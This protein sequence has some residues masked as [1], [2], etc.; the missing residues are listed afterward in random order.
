MISTENQLEKPEELRKKLKIL[1]G[2]DVDGVMLDV[3]WGIVESKSPEKYDWSAY[4]QLFE[5]IKEEGLK[6]QAIMSFHQCGGNIGDNIYIPIPKWVREIGESNPDIF[7]TNRK[8]TGN[9]ECLSLGVD[10]QPLFSGRTAIQVHLMLQSVFVL[11]LGWY[12]ICLERF[13]LV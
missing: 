3:W 5:I 7:Y 8:G 4:R 13:L 9:K 10:D 1:K 2:A 11:I 12:K 6:L